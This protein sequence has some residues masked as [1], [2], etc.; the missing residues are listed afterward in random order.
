MFL[1]VIQHLN[2]DD[3]RQKIMTYFATVLSM[4]HPCLWIKWFRISWIALNNLKLHCI[5]DGIYIY[6]V[7]GCIQILLILKQ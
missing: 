3:K 4:T 5:T 2:P 6:I 1:V 7:Y